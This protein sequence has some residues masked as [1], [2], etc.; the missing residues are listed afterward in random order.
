MLLWADDHART[1]EAHVGD[2]FVCSETVAID[3]I[4]TDEAACSAET[5][6]AVDGNCL[7]LYDDHVMCFIDECTDHF[8]GRTCAI[9]KDHVHVLDVVGCEVGWGV[10]WIV[11]SYYQAHVS[12]GE[13]CEDIFER[14]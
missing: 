13:V 7:L 8:K 5:C 3:E 10:E 9:I 2:D 4:C 6:F 11:E 12:L 14:R 1:H